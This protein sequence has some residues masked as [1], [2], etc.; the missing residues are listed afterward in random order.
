MILTPRSRWTMLLA[1]T[2]L[3]LSVPLVSYV[4][5]RTEQACCLP[6]NGDSI[7]IPLAE[8]MEGWKVAMP[9]VAVLLLAAASRYRGGRSFWSYDRDRPV[10]GAACSLI[11][12][13]AA[14]TALASAAAVQPRYPLE[15]LSAVAWAWL[16]LSIRSS[17]AGTDDATREG[18]PA[19]FWAIPLFVAAAVISAAPFGFEWWSDVIGFLTFLGLER[20]LLAGAVATLVLTLRA[21]PRRRGLTS[22]VLLAGLTVRRSHRP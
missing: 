1:G 17:I 15:A 6:T 8:V 19:A 10:T 21:M 2:G 9:V 12:G 14:I 4:S 3:Y 20:Y 13:S 22:A 16:F 7:G 18:A 11:L 5:L